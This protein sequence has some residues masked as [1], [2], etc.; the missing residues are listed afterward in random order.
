MNAMNR[1]LKVAYLIIIFYLPAP[2]Q[3]PIEKWR[4]V[5]YVES[6]VATP[7][8]P[9]I[10]IDSFGNTWMATGQAITVPFFGVRLVKYDSAGVVLWRQDLPGS[11]LGSFYI[12]MTLDQSGYGY[13]CTFNELSTSGPMVFKYS[14]AGEK[15]W[16]V[17][18]D[19]NGTDEIGIVQMLMDES[20]GQLVMSGYYPE[21]KQAF[22][23]ALDTSNGN[24][25]WRTIIP[26][27]GIRGVY[28]RLQENH[29]QVHT[30]QDRPEG[31]FWLNY[32]IGFD[33]V[34]QA[35]FEKPFDLGFSV[36]NVIISSNGDVTYSGYYGYGAVRFNIAGDM[37]WE[38]KYPGVGGFNVNS[39]RLLEDDSFNVYLTG[40]IP[41]P[42][43]GN[44]AV[45]TK[46]NTNGEVVWQNIFHVTDGDF[47]DDTQELALWRDKLIVAGSGFSL[48]AQRI[49]LFLNVYNSNDGTVAASVIVDTLNRIY[50]S[51]LQIAGNNLFY[52]GSGDLLALENAVAVTGCYELPIVSAA[53]ALPSG[54]VAAVFPNPV[55]DQ[56]TIRLPEAML[57][58]AELRLFGANGRLAARFVLGNGVS[59]YTIPIAHLLPGMYFWQIQESSG[60]GPLGNGRFLIVRE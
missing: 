46:I 30:I 11:I 57:Q 43:L 6:V 42:G 20:T 52:C 44:E 3:I 31:F 35:F 4:A 45:T 24:I 37:L 9:A 27:N 33:G 39:R 12:D 23:Q 53:P 56:L 38:Y 21:N 18:A 16:E 60:R 34:V 41:L 1:S 2:S 54:P 22:V 59:L 17:D 47:S 8:I 10:R 51:E 15:R 36:N 28:M 40:T 14:P 49:V 25:I 26:G 48:P 5:E 55:S 13:I 58:D 7:E 29:I 19:P 50:A 32:L